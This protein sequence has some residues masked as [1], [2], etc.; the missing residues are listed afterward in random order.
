MN[1][2]EWGEEK[3]KLNFKSHG[4]SLE[5]GIPVF[6][7]DY[8]L[9]YLDDRR[10]YGEDRYITIGRNK[11]TDILYVVYTMRGHDKTRLISVRMAERIERK[12]YERNMGI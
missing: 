4:M 12:L 8:R 10:D 1:K 2:F 6:D 9:E 3:D 7:D 11:Y 5:A